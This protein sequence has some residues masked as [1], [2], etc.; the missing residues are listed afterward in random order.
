[1]PFFSRIAGLGGGSST[2]FKSPRRIFPVR[3]YI[4]V[5]AGQGA[6]WNEADNP[7]MPLSSPLRNGGR[8]GYTKLEMIVPT[9][10]T[11]EL[12]TPTTVF[13]GGAASGG[14]G[15]APGP[16]IISGTTAGAPSNGFSIGGSWMC[17]V[18]GG[19]GASGTYNVNPFYS[20]AIFSVQASPGGG[21]S[22]GHTGSGTGS[23][24]G[25]GASI[26]NPAGPW[27]F[28]TGYRINNIGGGGGGAPGGA[29]Y[30]PVWPDGN[31]GSSGGGAGV[32]RIR[33][34]TP[35][36]SGYLPSNPSIYMSLVTSSNGTSPSAQIIITN[37]NTGGTRTY[38]SSSTV[39]VADIN[40]F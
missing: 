17:I 31:W 2:G 28:G 4:E 23:A 29:A 3:F 38:T 13:S 26:R 16:N 7:G 1:M 35:G 18:G 39:P 22:G 24:G 11:L 40:E 14:G 32:I 20:P 19:A 10:N 34:E 33:N 12:S 9:A 25:N 37:Y 8:G 27:P 6:K 36:T 30:S 21:G 5:F 15:G